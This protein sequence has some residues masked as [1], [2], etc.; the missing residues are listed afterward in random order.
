MNGLYGKTIQ[1][2]IIDENVI[3]KLQAEFVKYHANYGGMTM[4]SLSDSSYYLT[5]EDEDKLKNKITKPV[6]LGGF[7]LGYSRRI[8]L[9]YLRKSNPYFD[10][11]LLDNQLEHSPFYTDTDSIQIHPY[12]GFYQPFWRNIISGCKEINSTP[13][14]GRNFDGNSSDPHGHNSIGTV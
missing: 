14:S 8:M 6:Y 2:P 13:C 9:G 7:I 12:R 4:K 1:R 5:N 11:T 10:R 3:I